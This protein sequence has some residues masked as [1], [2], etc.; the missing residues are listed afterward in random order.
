MFSLPTF[1]EASKSAVNSFSIHTD[2]CSSKSQTPENCTPG[3]CDFLENRKPP[4]PLYIVYYMLIM[5]AQAP[6]KWVSLCGAMSSTLGCY[7]DTPL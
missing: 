3:A 5:E 7:I 2:R 6:H 1:D 4:P